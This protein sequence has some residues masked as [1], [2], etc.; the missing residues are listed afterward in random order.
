MLDLPA[1]MQSVPM[2][3]YI[4]TKTDL[5]FFFCMHVLLKKIFLFILK[6]KKK[7]EQ[8]APL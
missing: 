3:I 8:F 5:A 7:Y 4:H 6:T 2:Y 1:K